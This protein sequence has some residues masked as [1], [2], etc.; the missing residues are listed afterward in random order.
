M[1]ERQWTNLDALAEA[2]RRTR[3]REEALALVHAAPT[4]AV[5]VLPKERP[6]DPVAVTGGRAVLAVCRPA[7]PR[8]RPAPPA[9]MSLFQRRGGS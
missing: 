8:P 6:A 5:P 7:P 4:S 9:P 1:G 2:I 3:T